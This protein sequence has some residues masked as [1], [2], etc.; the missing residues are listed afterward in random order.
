MK[1]PEVDKVL[2]PEVEEVQ[3]PEPKVDMRL[4]LTWEEEDAD[5]VEYIKLKVHEA[6]ERQFPQMDRI[7][8][9]LY[10]KTLVPNPPG[11]PKGYQ[12]YAD[13]SYIRDWSR[14]SAHDLQTFCLAAAAEAYFAVNAQVDALAEAAFAKYDYDDA[15]D[16]AYSAQL[17]GTIGDKT[18]RAKRKTQKERWLALFKTLYR[19]CLDEKVEKLET[20]RRSAERIY[21][22][23]C[24]QQKR[25]FYASRS[26]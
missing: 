16:K 1:A 17:S 3:V 26:Q 9:E 7:E 18:A 8:R 10:D 12:M 19:K 14:V 11:E 20:H 25:E 4:S 22:Q 24:E 21:A 23:I 13:G 6:V 5:A 2:E 15:Y